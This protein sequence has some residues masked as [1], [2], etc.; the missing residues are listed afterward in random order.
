MTMAQPRNHK[1]ARGRKPRF[2]RVSVVVDATAMFASGIQ[3]GP[4]VLCKLFIYSPDG[5]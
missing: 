2:G 3:I 4:G 1:R 5:N